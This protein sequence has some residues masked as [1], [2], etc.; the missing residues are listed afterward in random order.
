MVPLTGAVL[1]AD[2]KVQLG[3][4]FIVFYHAQK[5]SQP[6]KGSDIGLLG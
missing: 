3:C 6:L 2:L 5:I 4:F 1:N